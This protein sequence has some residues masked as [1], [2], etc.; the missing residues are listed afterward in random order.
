MPKPRA[1]ARAV[2]G[3]SARTMGQR[4]DTRRKTRQLL[5]FSTCLER[6]GE[7]ENKSRGVEDLQGGL[8]GDLDVKVFIVA[9]I[10]HAPTTI[11]TLEEDVHNAMRRL[12][13]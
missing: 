11:F 6:C 1:V 8:V 4:Q 13:M 12:G 3:F 9:I 2:V 5:D 10:T 7:L